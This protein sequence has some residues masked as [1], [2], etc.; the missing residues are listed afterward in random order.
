M[1][2]N[3]PKLPCDSGSSNPPPI[4]DDDEQTL[5]AVGWGGWA[6]SSGYASNWSPFSGIPYIGNANCF[7][8]GTQVVI[9]L[10]LP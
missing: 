8:A 5:S 10:T 3:T 9:Y 4:S 6:E 1:P 7:V 2:K